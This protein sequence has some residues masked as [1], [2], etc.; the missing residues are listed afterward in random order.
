MKQQF[1]YYVQRCRR[2]RIPIRR[3]LQ[4]KTK[5]VNRDD[6]QDGKPAKAVDVA[7][8]SFFFDF[9][10]LTVDQNLHIIP[11]NHSGPVLMSRLDYG[12]RA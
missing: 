4:G 12:Y 3:Y 2:V 6:I 7:Q 10:P 8:V 11:R 5:C 1:I 9:Y